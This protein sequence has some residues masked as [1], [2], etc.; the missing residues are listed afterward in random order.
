MDEQPQ[1]DELFVAQG[2][3]TS[4]NHP[5]AAGARDDAGRQRDLRLQNNFGILDWYI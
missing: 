4:N 2:P 1:Q 3:R 5:S